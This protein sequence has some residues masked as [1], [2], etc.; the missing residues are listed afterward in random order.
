MVVTFLIATAE[1]EKKMMGDMAAAV[2]NPCVGC[3]EEAVLASDAIE[4]FG[5]SVV[6]QFCELCDKINDQMW[7]LAT[8]RLEIR[9]V[10][11]DTLAILELL[12]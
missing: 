1:R 7:D 12:K 3:G 11:L 10:N 8:I 5:G 9:S 6:A 4:Y 2:K